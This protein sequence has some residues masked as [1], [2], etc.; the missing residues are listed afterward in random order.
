MWGLTAVKFNSDWFWRLTVIFNSPTV[1]VNIKREPIRKSSNFNVQWTKTFYHYN[2]NH[3]AFFFYIFQGLKMWL[4]ICNN[5]KGNF[6]W[7]PE[8]VNVKFH[9]ITSY[10]LN[11]QNLTVSCSIWDSFSPIWHL[12][13]QTTMRNVF[14]FYYR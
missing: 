5:T 2:L 11:F 7:E 13:S 6:S 8:K 3:I 9:K 14:G 4:V 1:T 12:F 10:T